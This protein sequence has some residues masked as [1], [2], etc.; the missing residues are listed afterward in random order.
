MRYRCYITLCV[1]RGVDMR[2]SMRVRVPPRRAKAT[3]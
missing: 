1:D 2:V 3:Y